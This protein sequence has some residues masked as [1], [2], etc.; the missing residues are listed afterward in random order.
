[1]NLQ[2]IELEDKKFQEINDPDL[3]DDCCREESHRHSFQP[4][5]NAMGKHNKYLDAQGN[6]V[7][8]GSEASRLYR[9]EPVV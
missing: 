7:R 6:P 9:S 5:L 3:S 1:V 2:D 4:N 8:K